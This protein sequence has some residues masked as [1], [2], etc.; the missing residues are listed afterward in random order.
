MRAIL[1]LL[2]HCGALVLPPIAITQPRAGAPALAAPAQCRARAPVLGILEPV[3]GERRAA[4]ERILEVELARLNTAVK[5]NVAR[6]SLPERLQDKAPTTTEIL[7]EWDARAP[8]MRW[9]V[10]RWMIESMG[11]EK[12]GVWCP[13]LKRL[14]LHPWQWTPNAHP[15]L[16]TPTFVESLIT[17]RPQL[18]DEI[19]QGFRTSPL[20]VFRL[21]YRA[22]IVYA[23]AA[24]SFLPGPQRQLIQRMWPRLVE[25]LATTLELN[26]NRV[27]QIPSS[28]PQRGFGSVLLERP[29]QWGERLLCAL[30]VRG[31]NTVEFA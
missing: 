19:R 30:G 23:L 25:H 4:V 31:C 26:H 29:R 14:E 15:T 21:A 20:R 11:I 10:T 13:T 9:A 6:L 22:A 16:T 12:Y 7:E 28:K 8:M 17:L 2:S 24:L 3:P 1:L 18:T 27:L 5:L